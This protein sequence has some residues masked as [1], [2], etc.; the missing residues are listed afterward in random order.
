MI[1]IDSYAKLNLYLEV[2]ETRPDGYHEIETVMQTI[3]LADTL[4]LTLAGSIEVTCSDPLVPDGPDNI[5][6]RAAK[7]LVRESGTVP[8]ASIHIEK[9]IPSSAGLAGGSTNAAAAL[10]ALAILWELGAPREDLARI[11][12]TLGSDVPFFFHGG[13]A[14]CRGR[15]ERVEPLPAIDRSLRFLLVTPDIQVSS[16]F[17]YKELD[18]LRLTSDSSFPSMRTIT[19][20]DDVVA[21]FVAD[22]HNRLEDAVLPAYPLVRETRDRLTGYCTGHAMMSGSGPSLFG[23]LADEEFDTGR[24]A[25]EFD[26]S[27][28]TTVVR[29]MSC[30]FR[31]H[32]SSTV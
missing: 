25:L 23:L 11:G 9:K 27:R 26:D 29:P 19:M 20:S 5:V 16:T 1:R 32:D 2:G 17:A 8:G 30:G 12:L 13:T 28:I 22:G 10:H 18:R 3:S 4:S 7:A 6:Y 24:L 31:L 14:L 21:A 15:G